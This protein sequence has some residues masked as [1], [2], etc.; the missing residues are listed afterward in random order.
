MS[1]SSKSVDPIYKQKFLEDLCGFIAKVKAHEVNDPTTCETIFR[2]DDLYLDEKRCLQEIASGSFKTTKDR[3]DALEIL[4]QKIFNRIELLDGI[5]ITRKQTALGQ[6]DLQL[7]TIR[8]YLYDVLGMAVDKPN[9]DYII[10]ECKNYTDPVGKDEI[11][12]MCWRASKGSCLSFFIATEYTSD[13]IQEISYFNQNRQNLLS[14][15]KGVYIIP[16]SLSMIE[17]VVEN[18]VN[19][20]Y[21]I[22]WAIKFSKIISIRNYLKLS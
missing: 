12:R 14:I 19:F 13:A 3:G 6:L 5:S 21:F 11:E 20:C 2:N 18:D 10:G 16:L 22:K 17:A 15:H 4:I 8:E 1:T 9:V 7:V